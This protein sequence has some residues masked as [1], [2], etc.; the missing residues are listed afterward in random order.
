M[1]WCQLWPGTALG[2]GWA[3][4]SGVATMLGDGAL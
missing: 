1:P 3:W 4:T 2:A